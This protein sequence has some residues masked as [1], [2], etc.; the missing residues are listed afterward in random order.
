MAQGHSGRIHPEDLAAVAPRRPAG[1]SV[2]EMHAHTSDRSLDSGVRAAVLATQ[3][4]ARGLDGVCLTEHN[5]LWTP[6]EV[7]ELSERCEVTVLAGMELGTDVGHIL[8]YGLDR[9]HPELLVLET[10]R[11]IVEAEGAAM[12][13]AHP[14]RTFYGRRPGWEELADWFEG[15]EVINGDHSD[16]ENG[17]LVRQ[18]QE[19]GLATVAGSD[20]HSRDA[21]GRVATVF[22]RLVL[23]I[24]HIAHLLRSCQATAVD[25]RPRL[26]QAISP[27]RP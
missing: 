10:L 7:R 9:Y 27:A 22:P 15:V 14:M 25:F 17:Y 5:S 12:V 2:F 3:A 24:G 1:G 23:D 18:A 16:G 21:V 26:E 4:K 13:Q 8:V 19:C 11:P 20:V 6:Q